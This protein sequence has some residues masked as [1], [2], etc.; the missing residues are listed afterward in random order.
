MDGAAVAEDIRDDVREGVDRETVEAVQAM[1]GKYKHGWETDIET[2][3]APKGLNEDIVRLISDKNGEPEWLLDWRL[4]AFRRWQKMEEPTWAMVSY[5]A[6]DY[7]EQY[8]YARPKALAEKP[9]SLDEVDPKLLATYA[10]LGIP[11]KEQAL[12]AGVTA[13]DGTRKVA[14]D[15]VFDSVSVGTTFKE[16]LRKAGVIFCSISEAVREYPDLVRRY[17]GS[18]VPPTDNFFATLNSA[19]FSDGSFVYVPAGV[20]CPMELST[21]FRINAEN[22]GQFERT[23]IIA[24]EGAYVSYL[25]GCTAPKRDTNQLHAAVV[26]IVILKDAEVKYSTVQ[27][28]YPGDENGVGGIYNFVTKRA[29]CRG[30]RAKVMWTQVETG[31]A[32]TWKYPSC[33][34][35]GDDSQGEFYSIAIANNAQQADT[36]T[37]MIHLGKRTKSRIVS[38]GIS[39][40]RAQNTYRGLVSMHPKAADSRNYTQCDSLL[41]GDKC[42]AHTVPYIEVKNTSSRVEHEATTSKVDDDQLFYCRSRGMDEEEAVALVVN[43]FCREVLQ[44]LPMEFAMEAQALVA[45]SLEGSVG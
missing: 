40:G 29:D 16:E 20:R 44:A 36:G 9:K 1:A 30:D 19:V 34:L 24:D 7:Q 11:L 4:D 14:V 43:G 41:I 2:E 10:K 35:R 45:I 23:L 27:N 42:G 33:I 22:T 17:L 26:E 8:Y 39:A 25:E 3:F 31:S 5:P 32:I 38:K 37:K 21:Y 6:I 18:V 13:G 12:L 28:W 15:A